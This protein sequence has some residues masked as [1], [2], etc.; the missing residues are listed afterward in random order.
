LSSLTGVDPESDQHSRACQRSR[1]PIRKTQNQDHTP[2]KVSRNPNQVLANV[3][4]RLYKSI[5]QRLA[6]TFFPAIG[7]AYSLAALPWAADQSGGS[8]LHWGRLRGELMRE[9][10]E[11]VGDFFYVDNAG[12]MYFCL[13]DFVRQHRLPDS[14]ALRIALIE[15]AEETFPGIRILEEWN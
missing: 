1:V 9:S 2:H 11:K 7:Q 3:S 10:F 4:I 6:T 13:E 14:P 8:F 15:I 12:N 5:G